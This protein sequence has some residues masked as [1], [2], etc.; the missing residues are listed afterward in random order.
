MK[1][2]ENLVDPVLE[3]FFEKRDEERKV[4]DDRAQRSIIYID[5]FLPEPSFKERVRRTAEELVEVREERK[6]EKRKTRRATYD[7]R[8][9][10]KTVNF[11]MTNSRES[12]GLG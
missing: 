7:E 8:E 12:M 6:E 9:V 5:D 4:A 3:K 10:Q 1:D 2:D 11:K